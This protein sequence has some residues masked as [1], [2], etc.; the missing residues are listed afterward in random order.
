[1]TRH[2]FDSGELGRNDP[3][4]DRIGEGLERYAT[5]LGGEPPRDLSSRIRAALD[6]EPVAAG[7]WWNSLLAAFAPWHGP[8]RLALGAAIV[9]AAALGALVVSDLAERART[10][11]GSTPAPSVIVSPSPTP[12][13]TPTPSPTPTPTSTPTSTPTPTIPATAVPT[14]SDDHGGGV[15]TASPSETADDNSGS[16]SDNSGPGG[17]D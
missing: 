3:E 8:A 4:M 11:V 1:M 6:E 15:E 12:T 2:P 5:E 13:P 14:A 10:D 9:A 16:G 17:G 7:G